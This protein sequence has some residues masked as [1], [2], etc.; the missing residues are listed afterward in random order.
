MVLAGL[1][2]EVIIDIVNRSFAFWSYQTSLSKK[3]QDGLIGSYKER[4]HMLETSYE[5][6]ITKFRHEAASLKKKIDGK[7]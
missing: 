6:L 5:S 3:Y 2:P 7:R 4:L 1:S